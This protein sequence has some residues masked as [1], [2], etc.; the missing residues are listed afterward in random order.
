MKVAIGFFG[1]TRSLKYTIDSIRK[2]IFSALDSENVEFD[3]FVHCYSLTTYKNKRTKENIE[4]SFMIDNDEYKLL[5]PK[6]YKQDNQDEIAKKLNLKRFRTHRD[7]WS[8]DYNSV[9]NFILGA[10]SKYILTSMINENIKE[11]DYIVFMRPD[12]LYSHKLKSEFFKLVT[13][14]SIVIPNFHCFGKYKVNDRFAITNTKNYKI[15][16]E[17]YTQL[18]EISKNQCLH[19]ETILGMILKEKNSLSI[20]KVKFN[21]CRVRCDGRIC[22]NDKKLHP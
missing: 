17:V 10:Y 4:N 15:Y 13:D 2:N 1:I 12:C 20:Q 11:Y 18:L 3:V 22:D 9:D 5:N 14:T 7:P 6:W 19:S 8:T 16:G 21:F